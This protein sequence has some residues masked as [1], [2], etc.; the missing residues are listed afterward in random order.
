[1]KKYIL[2]AIFISSLFA[3]DDSIY[4]DLNKTDYSDL[5]VFVGLDC[6]YRYQDNKDLS[7]KAYSYGIYAGI[8]LDGWDII[9]KQ[10]KNKSKDFDIFSN[11][12]IANL[13]ISGSGTDMTYFGILVGNSKLTLDNSIVINS[14]V[15]N[16]N[17]TE[18]FYG[19]HIGHRYKFSRNFY[20][21]IE[22]EYIKYNFDIKSTDNLSIGDPIEFIYGIEYRF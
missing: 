6:G 14:N 12:I 17:Q 8:P 3:K 15:T 1:M 5:R 21:K 7:N 22:L 10:K 11:S 2:I 9:I 18:T 20:V 4:L 13:D 16:N 19:T